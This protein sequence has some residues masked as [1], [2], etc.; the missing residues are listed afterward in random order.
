MTFMVEYL[1]YNKKMVGAVLVTPSDRDTPKARF[2]MPPQYTP[3]VVSRFWSKVDRSGGPDA[4]WLWTTS[5]FGSGYGQFKLE[6][7]NLRA[8]RV[9]W[10]ITHGCVPDGLFVLHRCDN[11]R[12]VNP[13]HLW[14]GTHKDNMADMQR[15]GRAATGDANGSRLHPERLVRGD[16]HP[17][18]K[19]LFWRCGTDN[20]EAKLTE[21]QVQWIRTRWEC[22]GVRLQDL[23]VMYG[24]SK[25]TIWKVVNR[26]SWRHI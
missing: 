17:A 19:T 11:R 4:C 1:S 13:A 12:C 26:K 23:A 18:R 24:V 3:K 14:L 8:H 16:V 22:G 6:P 9:A 2:G 25:Q 5:T 15:K 10:E 21:Q 20:G 7:R